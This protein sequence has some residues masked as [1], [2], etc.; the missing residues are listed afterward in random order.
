MTQLNIQV[1]NLLA[2]IDEQY[3]EDLLGADGT[4]V[5]S[6]R[7]PIGPQWAYINLSHLFANLPRPYHICSDH[8][9]NMD[10]PNERSFFLVKGIYV[11]ISFGL[12]GLEFSLKFQ[13]AFADAY[14]KQPTSPAGI[15]L[16]SVNIGVARAPYGN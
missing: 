10:R 8:V 13:T 7:T 3:L 9:L 11:D 14:S 16:L 5:R 1:L 15:G 2:T 12:K 6:L 4:M